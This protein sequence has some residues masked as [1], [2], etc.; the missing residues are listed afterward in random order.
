MP[1]VRGD[2]ATGWRDPR[3]VVH[4]VVFQSGANIELA[5]G[6]GFI[7]AGPNR[8]DGFE[9]AYEAPTCLTCITRTP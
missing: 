5:C 4:V 6:R 1:D 3:G 8:D 2:P 7:R 9:Y